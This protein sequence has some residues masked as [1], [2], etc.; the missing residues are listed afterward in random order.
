M[1]RTTFLEILSL[2]DDIRSDV[3]LLNLT[4]IM[5]KVERVSQLLEGVLREVNEGGGE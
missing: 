5:N 3:T 4:T 1:K 2:I